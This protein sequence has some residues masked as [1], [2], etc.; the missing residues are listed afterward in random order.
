MKSLLESLN[1]FMEFEHQSNLPQVD[2]LY[3]KV[4]AELD[5]LCRQI[6]IIEKYGYTRSHILNILS[7]VLTIFKKSPLGWR[8]QNLPL[9]NP[10]NYKIIDY[11]CDAINKAPQNTVE[12]CCEEYALSCPAIQQY[13]NLVRHQ[14][15][16]IIET[17]RIA[18]ENP[19]V[20]SIGCGSSRDIWSIQVFLKESLNGKI[21]LID[22][23][24]KALEFSRAR[25]SSLEGKLEFI[26]GN[27]I[28]SIYKLEQ[29]EGF[30]LVVTGGLF[31]YLTKPVVKYLIKHI[32]H[33]LLKPNGKLVFT[34]IAQ[35]N[36]YRPFL[37]YFGNL[38]LVERDEEDILDIWQQLGLNRQDINLKRDEDNLRLIVEINK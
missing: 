4:S 37:E 36:P 28:Q 14:A 16:Q 12:Y 20:L 11:I 31:D 33:Y 9:D 38:T 5:N 3:Q 23:D 18:H 1:S 30:D 34:N 17:F 8:M 2:L 35:G 7:P 10:G 19:R 27:I 21:V 32:Y 13:R 22:R 26:Q 29:T 15:L 6:V 25:L 24:I